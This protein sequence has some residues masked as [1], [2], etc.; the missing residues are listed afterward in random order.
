MNRRKFLYG[1]S[2]FASLPAL[3]S[4]FLRAQQPGMNM[5]GGGA[6]EAPAGGAADYTLRIEPCT[7]EIAPG[8]TVKTTA[9]N[10]QVPGPMLKFKKN[11][12]VTIDVTNGTDVADLVH[13]HGLRTDSLNDGAMEEGSPMINPGETFRYQLTP[14]PSGTRWYHTHNSAKIGRAHV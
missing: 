7:L 11:A 6:M 2:A 8:V 1:A 10:G 14:N 9:Y 13:W 4:P 3:S 5:K 12:P